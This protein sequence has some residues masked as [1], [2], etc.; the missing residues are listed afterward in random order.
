MPWPLAE[1]GREAIL[2]DVQELLPFVNDAIDAAA[3]MLV[4]MHPKTTTHAAI[5]IGLI[6][7]AAKL[8]KN[9]FGTSRADFARAASELYE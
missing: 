7:Y 1:M 2:D 5:Q 4:A 9:S 8:A 3:M 6:Q